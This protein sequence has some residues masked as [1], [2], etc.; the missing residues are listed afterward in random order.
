V[1]AAGESRRLGR[2][3]QLLRRRG[4]PL[5]AAAV[6]AA[7]ASQ[8]GPIVVVLG[9][10]AQRLRALLARERTALRVVTNSKW[11]E[12]LST[13]L[14]AGL[15]AVP[16][17]ARAVLV[18]LVDQPH[19]TARSLERLIGAW[20]RHPGLP[21]AALYGGRPGVPAILPRATWRAVRALDGDAGARAVLR[22]AR[23]L[24]LVEMPEAA[25]DLDTPDD[26]ARLR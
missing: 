14:Q 13:S 16:R 6:A 5:L 7:A 19:V 15:A 9:A 25:F 11:R 10:H 23:R 24:T 17:D 22:A 18:L 20:R 1:L 4:R 21:A 2:P 12:G 3:K 8:S 26:A